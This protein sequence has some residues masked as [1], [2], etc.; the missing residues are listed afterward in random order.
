MISPRCTGLPLV[1]QSA[2]ESFYPT[3][4]H[5][6][7]LLRS[8]LNGFFLYALRRTDSFTNASS[9]RRHWVLHQ[10]AIPW[11]PCR[12][13]EGNYRSTSLLFNVKICDLIS[14][15]LLFQVSWARFA[16]AQ[17]YGYTLPKIEEDPDYELLTKRKDP[18]QIF[19][20][21]EPGWLVNLAQKQILKPLDPKLQEYYKS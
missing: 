4:F 10:S 14:V 17:K 12:S 6:F 13:W 9:C 7:L 15:L 16:L 20:G 2:S 5:H 1:P 8:S 11:V 18:R 3:Y 19:F 21:L